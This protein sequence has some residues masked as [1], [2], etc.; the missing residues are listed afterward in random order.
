MN[1]PSDNYTSKKSDARVLRKINPIPIRK[2]RR[3]LRIDQDMH[4][5]WPWK[6][7]VAAILLSFM[8]GGMG[9]FLVLTEQSRIRNSNSFFTVD[10]PRGATS[11]ITL[12]D[13]SQIWINAGSKISYPRAYNHLNREIY[14]EGEAYFSVRKNDVL[15]FIVRTKGVVAE[16]TGTEFNMKAYPEEGRIETTLV[17]GSLSLFRIE[18][19]AKMKEIILTPN[20]RVTIYDIN[21][22]P[23]LPSSSTEKINETNTNAVRGVKFEDDFNSELS[24]SWKDKRWLLKKE[25]FGALA[26][27]LE[28]QYDVTIVFLNEELKNY[29]IT[30][31]LKSESIKDVLHY[32]QL[33][34]PFHFEI[35]QKLVSVSIDLQRVINNQFDSSLPG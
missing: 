27:K 26:L 30:G 21:N 22:T 6:R 15:P 16:V 12:S 2:I 28:R 33:T 10:V 3:E 25:T 29:H 34:L 14:L 7:L 4:I 17:S 32:L 20:Q 1:D 35:Q 31:E 9:S 11:T 5:T 18:E 8:L 19:N 13:G 23:P 24:T